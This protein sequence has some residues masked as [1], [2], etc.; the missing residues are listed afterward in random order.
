M[1]KFGE[2]TEAKT[3]LQSLQ[4]FTRELQS[5]AIEEWPGFL[6]VTLGTVEVSPKLT[7]ESRTL[8]VAEQIF[9]GRDIGENLQY[10]KL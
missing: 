9:F 7:A 1:T 10:V 6:H 2:L 4:K 8:K 3:R 5:T